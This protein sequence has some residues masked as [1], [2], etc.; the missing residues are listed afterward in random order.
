MFIAE[1]CI[2]ILIGLIAG[3]FSSALIYRVPLKLNWISERSACPKCNHN[4]GVFDLFPVV[5][6]VFSGRKCR[7]CST[8]IPARYPL[9][10]CFSAVACLGIYSVFGFSIESLICIASVPFLISLLMIDLEHFI[11]PNQL[12]LA[13]FSLGSVRLGY[14]AFMGVSILPYIYGAFFFAFLSWFIGFA[15]EKVLKKEA[16]GFGDVKFFCVAGLWLGV[17][18]LPYFLMAAG[19]LGVIFA[20]IWQK[21][22]KSALFPFGPALIA[23]L[24]ILLLYKGVIIVL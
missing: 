23:S 15:M 11:L 22:N 17:E 20:L 7:Y 4:L 5:S 10:E 2:V 13:V 9:L 24:Y 12:V 8:K 1:I 19:I 18:I 3:S 14:A 6:W 16:L 21:I